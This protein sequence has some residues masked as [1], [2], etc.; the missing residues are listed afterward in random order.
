M[1]KPLTIYTHPSDARGSIT[2]AA[3]FVPIVG[4]R[5]D[6]RRAVPLVVSSKSEVRA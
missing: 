2:E 1:I 3:V 5:V 4:G 6:F